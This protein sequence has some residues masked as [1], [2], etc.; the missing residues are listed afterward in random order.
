[1]WTFL[2]GIVIFGALASSW[3]PPAS[4]A[5]FDHPDQSGELIIGMVIAVGCGGLWTWLR[6]MPAWKV[7]ES[8]SKRQDPNARV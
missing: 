5:E 6:K 2:I 4:A 7:E 3:T 1:V 8:I